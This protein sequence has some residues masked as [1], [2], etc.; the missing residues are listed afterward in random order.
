MRLIAHSF[1]ISKAH[2]ELQVKGQHTGARLAGH[3]QEVLDRF[4]LTDGRLLGITTDN[5]S[6]NYSMTRKLE[7]TLQASGIEWPALRNHIPCMAH[8][9]QL[10]LGAFMSSL[11]VKG[12]TKSW[13]A[14][15]RN[16][17]FGENERIDIGKS[18]RLR[19]EG[20]ARINKVSAMKPGLAKV[21][22]KVFISTYFECAETDLQ[23]AENAGCIDYADTWSAKRVHRLSKSQSPDR[24]TTYYGCEDTLELDTG[25]APARLPITWI[26][27]RV[28]YKPKIQRLPTTLHNTG[29]VDD[30]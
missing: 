30:C 7:T 4:D 5:A 3:L 23:I 17:Q 2:W 21:I 11:G 15:E 22:E 1:S 14:H 16:Q 18:Q 19:K 13:E 9:I 20:N 27:A 25:V 24:S 26:H 29:W 10:A 8:V 6:S 12:R 28:A